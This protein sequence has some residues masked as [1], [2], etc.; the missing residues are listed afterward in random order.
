RNEPVRYVIHQDAEALDRTYAEKDEIPGLGED[1]LVGRLEALGAH[2]PV[3]D[4]ARDHVPRRHAERP[5]PPR[6]DTDAGEQ[7]ARKPAQLGA[8]VDEGVDGWGAEV[9]VLRVPNDD[10]YVERAHARSVRVGRSRHKPS[11]I[12]WS[13]IRLPARLSSPVPPR[14]AP[15]PGPCS[16][17]GSG[18]RAARCCRA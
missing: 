8:G 13:G 2:D 18:S 9:L 4:V 7:L 11:S 17:A 12:P 14:R 1:D 15:G 6:H 16:R 3:A 5:L 10:G